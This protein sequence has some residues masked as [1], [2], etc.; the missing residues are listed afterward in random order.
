MC[1]DHTSQAWKASVI[2]GD[3][4]ELAVQCPPVGVDSQPQ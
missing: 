2:L 3:S 1:G 4:Q